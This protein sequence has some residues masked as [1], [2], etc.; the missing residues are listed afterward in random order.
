MAPDFTRGDGRSEYIDHAHGGIG[1]QRFRHTYLPIIGE[2]F[3]GLVLKPL[4]A[5]GQIELGMLGGEFLSGL[6]TIIELAA[7]TTV[8]IGVDCVGAGYATPVVVA[9]STAFLAGVV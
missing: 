1:F 2:Q 7:E 9:I 6:E 5:R 4:N 3:K 8:G